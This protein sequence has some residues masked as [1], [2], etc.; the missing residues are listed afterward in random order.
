M[1]TRYQEN[2]ATLTD[3]QFTKDDNE[4]QANGDAHVVKSGG[5]HG[6]TALQSSSMR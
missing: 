5:G 1:D 6:V 2:D 4:K 3:L